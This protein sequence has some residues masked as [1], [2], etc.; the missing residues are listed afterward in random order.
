VLV[1]QMLVVAGGVLGIAALGWSS[2]GAVP[3]VEGRGVPGV[4][5]PA[6]PRRFVVAPSGNEARYRVREQLAG[7][8]LP[9]DAVGVTHEITGA[10]VLDGGGNVIAKESKFVVG[11]AA[12]K[13]DRDRRDG[14]VRRRILETDS[15][16]TAELVPTALRGL[17][18]TLP[19]SGAATFELV[20]DLTVH[21]VT[22]ST[23]WHVTARFA[24]G[25][26]TGT[27]TTGFTFG[28]FGLA[29][30]RVP[31]VLSVAD[32]IRLEYDFT[33]VPEGAAAGS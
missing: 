21:G 1:K 12:L 2:P 32:S 19:D 25:Q 6:A 13:S 9:N 28:D 33:L 23:T 3:T 11:L 31:V 4:W 5:S 18:R 8:D 26:V 20:G 10:I 16:P 17:P 15:F 7:F 22:R 30:P 27:A 24:P 14:Y 29:R